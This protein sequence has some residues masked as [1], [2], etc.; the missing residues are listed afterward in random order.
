MAWRFA[1]LVKGPASRMG[2]NCWS[3]GQKVSLLLLVAQ[4]ECRPSSLAP[5]IS[6]DILSTRQRLVAI[7]VDAHCLLGQNQPM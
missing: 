4:V 1:R 2:G 5:P 6:M 3:R 7:R